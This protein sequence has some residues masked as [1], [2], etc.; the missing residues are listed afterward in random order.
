MLNRSLASRAVGI[1]IAAGMGCFPAARAQSGET[2]AGEVAVLGG[3]MLASGAKPALTGSTGLAVSRYAL[4]L[5]ETSFVPMHKQTIQPWPDRSTIEYSYLLDF[6]ADFHIRVPV[7]PHWAPYGIIGGGVLWNFLRQQTTDSAGLHHT[8]SYNQ[9]NAVLHTGG[10]VR[11]YL[12]ENW[13][14]R[15]EVKV[16]AGK[17]VF[18][19]ILMGVF[20]V[21][22]SNWP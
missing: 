13:G 11:Y 16:M 18:T 6:G 7:K 1:A 14:I 17:Q 19:Q 3:T 21:T 10:G 12:T 15:S 9:F 8:I 5:F 20:F 2:D 22:P 4:A